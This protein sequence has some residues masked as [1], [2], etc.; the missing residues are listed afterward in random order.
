[1]SSNNCFDSATSCRYEG[2]I[3]IV[4]ILLVLLL[5]GCSG[6]GSDSSTTTS[7]DDTTIDNQGGCNVSL[8]SYLDN[9]HNYIP[10]WEELECFTQDAVR[11]PLPAFSKRGLSGAININQDNID[12][13]AALLIN[14]WDS[15]YNGYGANISSAV[16]SLSPP[17]T[18]PNDEVITYPMTTA[19]ADYVFRGAATLFLHEK[20]LGRPVV[21][22]NFYP[23]DDASSIFTTQLEFESWVINELLPE[24]VLEAQAAENIKAEYYIP[25]PIEFEIFFKKYSGFGEG[26]FADALSENE[27]VALGQW[28]IDLIHDTVRPHYNGRLIAHVYNAVQGGDGDLFLQDLSFSQYDEFYIAAFPACDLNV[29]QN[30]IDEQIAY[31]MPMVA[32]DGLPWQLSELTV[33]SAIFDMCSTDL[34][35]IEADVYNAVFQTIDLQSIEPSGVQVGVYEIQSTLGEQTVIDYFSSK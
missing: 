31:Y 8:S 11:Q 23:I 21:W 22:V 7:P 6:S 32:R 1:M 18:G 4:Y 27:F 13:V 3:V 29:T 26:S 20:Q 5:S 17:F 15:I 10:T 33:Q 19:I 14:E 28:L 35:A 25:F 2:S 24:K 30:H 16:M 9:L 34:S 12:Q